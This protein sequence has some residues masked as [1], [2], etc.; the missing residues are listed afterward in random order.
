MGFLLQGGMDNASFRLG[1]VWVKVARVEFV[2][3]RVLPTAYRRTM[4]LVW[5]LEEGVRV[6]CRF[7]FQ[8]PL[9]FRCVCSICSVCRWLLRVLVPRDACGDPQVV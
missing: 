4:P 2:V 1:K 6:A 3:A 9:P 8:V 7:E 5:P